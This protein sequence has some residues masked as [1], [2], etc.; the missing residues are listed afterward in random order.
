MTARKTD[1]KKPNDRNRGKE[2]KKNLKTKW[3]KEK[4]F[5]NR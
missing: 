5:F 1:N 4:F 2:E 3:Q